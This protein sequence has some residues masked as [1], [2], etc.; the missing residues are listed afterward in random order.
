[1]TLNTF[2]LAGHGGKSILQGQ[3][4]NVTLHG[5]GFPKDVLVLFMPGFCY[6]AD[7]PWTH[8]QARLPEAA[9]EPC[10]DNTLSSYTTWGFRQSTYL[11]K[12]CATYV[13]H[14]F[15]LVLVPSRTEGWPRSLVVSCTAD[16]RS[17]ATAKVAIKPLLY[18]GLQYLDKVA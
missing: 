8:H 7:H 5:H 18:P 16:S 1:M 13:S 12:R 15:A 4:R 14:L 2:H 17:P 10:S 6:H 11:P 9:S 3:Q